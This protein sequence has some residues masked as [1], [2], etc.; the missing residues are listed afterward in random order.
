M[1][2][3]TNTIADVQVL[4]GTIGSLVNLNGPYVN[5]TLVVEEDTH[6]VHGT[7]KI[8]TNPPSEKPYTG[9]VTGTVYATGLAPFVKGITIQ[10]LIP[11]NNPL[12]PI[13]FPF[14]GFMQLKADNTG[15]G[16]FNFHGEHLENLPVEIKF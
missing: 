14:N 2:N 4:Q 7:V 1:S 8:Y 12:T 13:E 3:Q 15:V 9:N 11:S 10:G 5:F 16:G 6:K